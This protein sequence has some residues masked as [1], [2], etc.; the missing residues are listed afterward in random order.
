M[1]DGTTGVADHPRPPPPGEGEEQ[2]AAMERQTPHQPEDDEEEVAFD[3][4][5]AQVSPPIME[6][7]GTI[8]P[9]K[10]APPPSVSLQDTGVPK[11]T[12]ENRLAQLMLPGQNAQEGEEAV[13]GGSLGLG[14]GGNPL[15]YEEGIFADPAAFFR[16]ATRNPRKT[17]RETCCGEDGSCAF[18]V[19]RQFLVVVLAVALGIVGLIFS[20]DETTQDWESGSIEVHMILLYIA[21]LMGAY[22]VLSWV[23]S[24]FFWILHRACRPCGKYSRTFTFYASSFD[25]TMGKVLWIALGWAAYRPFFDISPDRRW[26]DKLWA[27]LL[28]LTVVD[29]ARIFVQRWILSNVLKSNY[30]EKVDE[31]LKRMHVAK[32]LMTPFRKDAIYHRATHEDWAAE[33]PE[34]METTESLLLQKQAS[35]TEKLN[36]I[37]ATDFT[38]PDARGEP[39][40]IKRGKDLNPFIESVF[41]RLTK[42]PHDVVR[43]AGKTAKRAAM[44]MEEGSAVATTFVSASDAVYVEKL[45]D[46]KKEKDQTSG[47]AIVEFETGKKI[48]AGMFR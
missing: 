32:L 25:G 42:L 26:L 35:L 8:Q 22:V 39:V 12:D 30:E 19:L 3:Q 48:E 7:P 29:G 41:R 17:C 36:Y 10:T 15:Q 2:K 45:D 24:I 11:I 33:I 14:G 38:L 13:W 9:K 1:S 37:R 47:D 16:R 43:E 31:L 20:E 21:A 27:T 23:E 28:A 34:D 46:A 40:A 18:G 5:P 6:E 44:Q 4:L